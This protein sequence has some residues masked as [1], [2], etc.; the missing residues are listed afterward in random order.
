MTQHDALL[1][2]V[3]AAPDDDLPR[4]V[5]ADWCDEN[6]DPDRA[7]FI[8]T[9]IEIAKGAKGEKLGALQEREKVLLAEHES[10]WTEPLWGFGDNIFDEP[11]GYRRGFVEDL[12]THGFLKEHGDELFRLAP[13]RR[14]LMMDIGSYEEL[15]ACTHLLKI[16][17]LDLSLAPLGEES[18]IQHL[19]LSPYL[20]NLTTLIVRGD[21]A[22]G[23]LDWIGLRSITR[24]K[25]LANLR[26]LDIGN[27]AL[28]RDRHHPDR[29]A[30]LR[31]IL[32]LGYSLPLTELRLRG[33][34][35]V[36]EDVQALAGQTWVGKL[37]DLDLSRNQIDD[38][39]GRALAESPHLE[40]IERLD[41]RFNR[42]PSSPRVFSIAPPLIG[43][44]V[45]QLLKQRF[46]ERV[47]LDGE[48]GA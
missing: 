46:G 36:S 44:E 30:M 23:G 41:M 6:G 2:A 24:S 10:R 34:D 17:S 9:Q 29:E 7:E 28:S 39:G 21:G 18:G 11:Y 45:Q 32:E 4:L 12:A 27:N 19:F 47:L 33:L 20:S 22:N 1:A 15:A 26:T 48:P 38:D 14:L 40:N 16:V 13:I 5:Y 31:H 8:R 25:S 42:E 3:C 43:H 37:K 35:L